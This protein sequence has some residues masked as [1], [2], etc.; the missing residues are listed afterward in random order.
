MYKR[1]GLLAIRAL[2][3]DEYGK[4]VNVKQ[5][6]FKQIFPRQGWVEHDP[7][8]ILDTQIDVFEDLVSSISLSDII[9]IGITN[10]RE[11]TVMWDKDTGEPLY[12]AIV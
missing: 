3:I 2:L 10:Q 6:E 8:E 4:L 5:K 12:N 1:Q 11:T 9:S 7:K